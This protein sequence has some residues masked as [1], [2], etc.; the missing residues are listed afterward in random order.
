MTSRGLVRVVFFS[1]FLIEE[2]ILPLRYAQ[3]QNDGHGMTGVK[4]K[5][6]GLRPNP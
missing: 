2:R 3:S 5:E 1:V 4:A 6:P